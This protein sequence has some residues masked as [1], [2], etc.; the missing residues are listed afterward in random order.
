MT[1]LSRILEFVR[2][3]YLTLW[4][5]LVACYGVTYA[6]AWIFAHIG[7]PGRTIVYR[8]RVAWAWGFAIH[9]LLVMVVTY[10]WWQKFGMF[11]AFWS[12]LPLY[13]VLGL[14]DVLCIGKFL[15]GLN[16]YTSYR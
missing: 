2:S 16:D 9:L 1:W 5:V 14:V 7:T 4:W 8:C 11:K 13:C 3:E 10:L 15:A 12:Y 6:F